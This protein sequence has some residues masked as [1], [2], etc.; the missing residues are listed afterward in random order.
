MCLTVRCSNFFKANQTIMLSPIFPTSG[1]RPRPTPPARPSIL[2]VLVVDDEPL[3]A[4][5]VT[6]LLQCDGFAVEMTTDSIQAL[7]RITAEPSRFDVLVSDHDMPQLCGS[8]LIDRARAAGFR[9]KVVL[10]SGS[11]SGIDAA[12]KVRR[13]DAVVSKPFGAQSLVPVLRSL[14]AR[15]S[16]C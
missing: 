4:E 7:A 11:L 8:E 15:P 13:A 16:T 2:R 12:D 1:I 3:I 14:M 10:H 6:T 9:G 5:I